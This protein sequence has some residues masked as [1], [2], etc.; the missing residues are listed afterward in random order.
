V[1]FVPSVAFIMVSKKFVPD[2]VFFSDPD[3]ICSLAVAKL[4]RISFDN[5]QM[6]PNSF[7]LLFAG[8]LQLPPRLNS[9]QA[10]KCPKPM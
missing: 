2:P 8:A 6:A 10:I 3:G 1:V 7:P 9:S 5:Q 4:A